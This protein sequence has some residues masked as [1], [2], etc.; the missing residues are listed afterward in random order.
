MKGERE[1][2]VGR[3]D[4]ESRMNE[5]IKLSYFFG[6]KALARDWTGT[7]LDWLQGSFAVHRLDLRLRLLNSRLVIRQLEQ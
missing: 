3:Y 7:G 2:E 4:R 5:A 6:C 1:I